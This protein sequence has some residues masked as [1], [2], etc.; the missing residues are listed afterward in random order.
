VTRRY[1]LLVVLSLLLVSLQREAH[2]HPI[3]HLGVLSKD[4]VAS[5]SSAAA[6]CLEC[7]LLAGGFNGAV[8]ASLPAAVEAPPVSLVFFSHR[9]RDADAPAW[10]ESRAPPAVLL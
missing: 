1:A 8:S 6:D 7:A 4:T 3:T 10:F 5:S 9:S 2:V